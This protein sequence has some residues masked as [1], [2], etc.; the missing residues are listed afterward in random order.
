VSKTNT[1]IIDCLT[2]GIHLSPCFY[3]SYITWG[4][5]C[6]VSLCSSEWHDCPHEGQCSRTYRYH[7][8]A[9]L[10]WS[11]GGL[12]GQGETQHQLLTIDCIL[13]PYYIQ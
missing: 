4:S 10:W 1:G 6:L 2:T 9:T 7:A 12:A 13:K 8:R 3:V 5:Y 11:P